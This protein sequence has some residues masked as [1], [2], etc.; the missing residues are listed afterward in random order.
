M[1]IEITAGRVFVAGRYRRPNRFQGDPVL[2]QSLGIDL[3]LK[4][5]AASPHAEDLR[6]PR[7]LH[8]PL[9]NQPIG[10]G[11]EFDQFRFR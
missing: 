4:L 7:D 8:H 1:L 3:H 11:A 6:D 10:L 2:D 9:T 5:L